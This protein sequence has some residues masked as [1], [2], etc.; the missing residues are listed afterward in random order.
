MPVFPWLCEWFGSD[1]VVHFKVSGAIC[2]VI[3]I[4]HLTAAK[5]GWRERSLLHISRYHDLRDAT[6]FHAT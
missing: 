5:L 2:C 6:L 4:C 1:C 3:I